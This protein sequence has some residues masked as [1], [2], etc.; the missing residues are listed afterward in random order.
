MTRRLYAY[1]PA[2]GE[3]P[4]FATVSGGEVRILS[5]TNS[6]TNAK[7]EI[8]FFV[9]ATDVSCHKVRLGAQKTA[10]LNRVARFALEEDLAS[11]IDETHF[12]VGSKL[13]DGRHHV[14]AVKPSLMDR[15]VEQTTALGFPDARL[16]A[17]ASVIPGVATAFDIGDTYLVAFPDQY[18]ALD[19]TLPDDALQAIF[20]KTSAP[21]EIIGDKLAKRLGAEPSRTT[22]LPP[23]A[24]LAIWA[25][26]HDDLTDLRQNDYASRRLTTIDLKQWKLPAALLG[27]VAALFLT[28]L[29]LENHNL[30]RLNTAMQQQGK[31]LYAA[32]NPGQAVPE[33]LEQTVRQPQSDPRAPKLDFLNATAL[34]YSALPEGDTHAIRGL[35][36]NGETG[37]LVASLSYPEYGADL[38]LKRALESKGLSVILGDSRQQDGQVLGDVTME[39]IQ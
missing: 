7:T 1:L 31:G 15:W 32:Q 14:H 34:L 21:T 4:E 10:D 23:L 25:N 5:H 8:V 27:A 39:A 20:A 13:S 33:N 24:Q 37:R 2:A 17:D 28:T 6:E 16:V 19:A 22:T 35:R 18:F 29:L 11:A 9:P 26:A 36:F 38:D 30:D 3:P 12:A